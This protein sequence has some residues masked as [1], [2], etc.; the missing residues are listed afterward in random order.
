MAVEICPEGAANLIRGIVKQA[1]RDFLNSAPNSAL[2]Q[3]CEQFFL[4]PGFT[5][6]TGLDGKMILNILEKAYAKTR[7]GRKQP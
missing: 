4:H 7:K 5:K 2:H 6:L 1:Q 3:E